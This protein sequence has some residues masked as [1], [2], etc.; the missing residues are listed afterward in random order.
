MVGYRICREHKVRGHIGKGMQRQSYNVSR[1]NCRGLKD[2][3]S[4]FGD[5]GW[6]LCFSLLL[7]GCFCG[8]A[9]LPQLPPTGAIVF[10]VP[11]AL[12][13]V[14][15]VMRNESSCQVFFHSPDL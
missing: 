9:V 10:F 5:G 7:R 1:S 6:W 3:E 12:L 2:I 11:I 14:G 4:V 15:H 13:S 8:S